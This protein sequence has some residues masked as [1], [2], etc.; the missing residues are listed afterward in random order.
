L[1]EIPVILRKAYHIQYILD[2]YFERK[3]IDKFA[4]VVRYEE[5][6]ANDCN[7]NIPRY[8]DTFEEEELI[9]I[10]E[11]QYKIAQIKAELGEVEEQMD[12]YLD[13]IITFLLGGQIM[14]KLKT[15]DFYYGAVLSTLFNNGITPMLIEGGTNRQVYDFITDSTEFRLFV[16]YRSSGRD[17][18]NGYKSWQ[19]VF[20]S[21]DIAEIKQFISEGRNLSIGLVCGTKGLNDSEFAVLHCDE[22]CLLLNSGKKSITISRI[23]GEKA[24]RLSIGGGR[25]NAIKIPS[26]RL[27]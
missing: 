22:I 23:K 21:N 13:W 20:S 10:E 8:V 18:E 11:V 17:G 9:D 1:S 15:A 16:K 3:D 4:H 14:S 6:K 19:F 24:F 25:D 12:R 2:A 27:Y 7:L 5:I 26:N